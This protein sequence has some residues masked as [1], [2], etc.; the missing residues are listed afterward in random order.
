MTRI[1]AQLN[2]SKAPGQDNFPPRL[3]KDGPTNIGP[4]LAH[5]INL[6]LRTY[7]VPGKIKIAEVIPLFKSGSKSCV[8]NYRPI[9]VLA[10]LSKVL[11]RI[12]YDQLSNYLEHNKLITTSQFGFRKSYNTELAVTLLTDQIRQ[13]MDH[14][15]LTGAVFIDL[16]KT[17][18][19]VE[20]CILLSKLPLYGIKDTEHAWIKSYLPNRY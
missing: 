5:I 13:A 2:P 1:L 9:S 17:F 3:L 12:V 8:E 16:Q 18:D 14:S 19:S 4:P 20:H 15:K 10:A 6:S 7:V 11:E